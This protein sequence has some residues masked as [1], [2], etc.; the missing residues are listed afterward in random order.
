MGHPK[1]NTRIDFDYFRDTGDDCIVEPNRQDLIIQIQ[2]LF[3]S[4]HLN[5]HR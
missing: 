4:F 2:I 5:K 1:P 3:L